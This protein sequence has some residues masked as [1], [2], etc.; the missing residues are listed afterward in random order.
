MNKI[1]TG[2]ITGGV[3]L[4]TAAGALA[5]SGNADNPGQMSQ[6]REEVEA[7]MDAGDYTTWS[8]LVADSPRGDKLLSVINENNFAQFAAAHQLMESGDKEGAK[9]IMDELG[10]S[11]VMGPK[12]DMADRQAVMDA[13]KNGDFEAWKSIIETREYGSQLL[14]LVDE[15]AFNSLSQILEF[16]HNSD[17]GYGKGI[18]GDLGFGGGRMRMGGMM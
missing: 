11:D 1:L 18:M 4:T 8:Q 10:L 5:F 17:N 9:A 3:I 2:L 15:N 6:I 7:A 13:I 14:D 16:A 12:Y